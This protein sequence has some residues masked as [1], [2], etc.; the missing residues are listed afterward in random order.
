MAR[1]LLC[2]RVKWLRETALELGSPG[3]GLKI[4]GDLKLELI[5]MNPGEVQAAGE[6]FL[7]KILGRIDDGE[8]PEEFLI[9]VLRE[10]LTETRQDLTQLFDA[11]RSQVDF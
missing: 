8:D 7:A 9:R 2:R 5:I 6:D 10:E 11:L 3:P 4:L 1:D